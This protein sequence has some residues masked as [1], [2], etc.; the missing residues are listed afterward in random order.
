[1]CINTSLL[2]ITDLRYILDNDI[3]NNTHR[4]KI[5]NTNESNRAFSCNAKFSGV[6]FIYIFIHKL[7]TNIFEFSYFYFLFEIFIAGFHYK[8]FVKYKFLHI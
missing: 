1:M 3:N 5:K 7:Q 8:S 4:N 6:L 2:C